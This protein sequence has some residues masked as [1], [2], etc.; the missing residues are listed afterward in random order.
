MDALYYKFLKVCIIRLNNELA[1]KT[2]DHF[3]V[4][5]VVIDNTKPYTPKYTMEAILQL[6]VDLDV[7]T[8]A[9]CSQDLAFPDYH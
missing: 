5:H 6:N 8:H 7:L 2:Q 3:A 4:Q 9:A 1:S